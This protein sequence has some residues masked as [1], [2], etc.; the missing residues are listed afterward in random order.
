MANALGRC[1]SAAAASPLASAVE[2][3]SFICHT[4]EPCVDRLS[5][6]LPNGFA[7][8]LRLVVT[9]RPFAPQE[10]ALLAA[11]NTECMFE[12]K[13]IGGKNAPIWFQDHFYG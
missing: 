11:E 12:F 13:C 6:V 1:S 7:R 3:A 8:Q 4:P 2:H 5:R 9:R 10:G